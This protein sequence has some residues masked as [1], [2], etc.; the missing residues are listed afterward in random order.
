MSNPQ[1][2]QVYQIYIKASAEKIWEAITSPSWNARY[3]YRG[4]MHYELHKGGKFEVRPNEFMK[5]MGLPDV[6]VDGEVL[7]CVPPHKLVQTYRMLFNADTMAEGFTTLTWE[8]HETQS[9]FCRLSVTHELG[10]A[11]IMAGMVSSDFNEQGSG[12]WGWILSDLKSLLET[13]EPM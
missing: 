5:Q 12:G 9:G 3:G 7:E 2:T 4:P 11:V 6:M 1:N 8:I 10:D 13:G